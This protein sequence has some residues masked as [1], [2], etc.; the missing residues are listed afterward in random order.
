MHSF[1]PVCLLFLFTFIA[2]LAPSMP[3]YSGCSHH[4]TLFHLLF[5]KPFEALAV[6]CGPCGGFPKSSCLSA[7]RPSKGARWR[8]LGAKKC[9]QVEPLHYMGPPHTHSHSPPSTVFFYDVVSQAYTTH[10]HSTFILCISFCEIVCVLLNSLSAF[11]IAVDQKSPN[12]AFFSL[13][14]FATFSAHGHCVYSIDGAHFS[15]WVRK[16]L[17]EHQQDQ[18]HSHFLLLLSNNYFP[19]FFFTSFY[20]SFF[21]HFAKMLCL[22]LF[23]YRMYI[24]FSLSLVH[25]ESKEWKSRSKKEKN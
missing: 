17:K 2:I 13:K 12:S 23:L 15:A 20:L 18:H 8:M 4:P 10:T 19:L 16:F 21:W 24:I 6:F 11:C 3:C 7:M 22:L 25:T 5:R 14:Y 1:K 9:K